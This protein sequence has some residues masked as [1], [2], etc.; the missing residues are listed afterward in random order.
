MKIIRWA[1]VPIALAAIATWAQ[2]PSANPG[3]ISFVAKQMNVP[4][5]GQFKK[6]SA[7]I[8]FDPTNPTAGKATVEIDVASL[9]LG[10]K[11]FN[12]EMSTKTWLDTRTYP[13]A[14]FIS[15]VIKPIAP[16]RLEIRGKLTIKG[17][18]LDVTVPV[19]FRTEG[20]IRVFDGALPIRRTAF[21]VGEDEWRDTSV[22]ADEVQIRF[23]LNSTPP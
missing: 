17:K 22:V 4:I 11:D 5:D 2:A 12:Y 15:S 9:D 1:G 7:Q 6:F 3:T 23:H 19:T 16:D 18:T 13:R 20:R 21:N 8:Q 14:T 10:D